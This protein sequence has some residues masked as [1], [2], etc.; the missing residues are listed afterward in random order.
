MLSD[1]Q[2]DEN[3]EKILYKNKI[4][5]EEIINGYIYV[6]LKNKK[7]R[8]HRLV[9][10]IKTFMKIPKNIVINHKDGNK[11]NNKFENLEAITIKENTKHWYEKINN[12]KDLK[13]NFIL[14][15]FYFY[16]IY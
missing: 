16:N 9:Y 1:F 10:E 7:I 15:N 12:K 6:I 5:K 11:L 13:K 3:E 4:L 8:K 14:K 2:I